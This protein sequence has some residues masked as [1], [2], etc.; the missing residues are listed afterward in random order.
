MVEG[1]KKEG[2]NINDIL[3]EQIIARN[4][5]LRILGNKKAV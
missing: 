5:L 4:E 3:K 2:K 1:F